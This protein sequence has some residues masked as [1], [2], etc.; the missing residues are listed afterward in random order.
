MRNSIKPIALFIAFA[1]LAIAGCKKETPE[2]EKPKATLSNIEVGLGNNGIGVIGRD[3]HLNMDILAGDKI[4]L[5]QI[6]IEQITG[7]TYTKTWSHEISWEEFK[8]VKNATV[9]K[10]FDIPEDAAE[11]KYDFLIIVKDHNGTTLEEK[12]TVSLYLAA[13]LP[14]D[15]KLYSIYTGLVDDNYKQLKT[16]YNSFDPENTNLHL[17][18]NDLLTYR[19]AVSGVKDDGQAIVLLINKKH[20][21]RPETF[22]AIDYSKVIVVDF[23]QHTG[24]A[25]SGTFSTN[26]DRS[27]T[28]VKFRNPTLKI[29]AAVDNNIPT[30]NQITGL[31]AWEPGNYYLLMIYKNTTHNMGL[32]YYLE[33]SVAL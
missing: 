26:I 1:T 3:F 10:H 11:G 28:P 32:F 24:M 8:G 31:R 16:I 7:E 25:T 12:R 23:A 33:V 29:G 27:T 13:N 17:N 9:H 5:V 22:D 30:G 2:P 20:N 6:K 18:K 15:P 4:D 14:V 21:H 19:A